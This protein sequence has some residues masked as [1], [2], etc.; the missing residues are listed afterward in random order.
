MSQASY[1]F[2]QHPKTPPLYRCLIRIERVED[3]LN[4]ST[5]R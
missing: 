4:M 5:I 1:F 2:S 3:K